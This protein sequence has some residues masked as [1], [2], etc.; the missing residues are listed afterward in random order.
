MPSRSGGKAAQSQ[1][2]RPPCSEQLPRH[3]DHQDNTEQEHE[4]WGLGTG[5]LSSPRGPHSL[6]T[7]KV[8]RRTQARKPASL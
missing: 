2:P 4:L 3:R 8:R 1:P 7:A 6:V 5:P